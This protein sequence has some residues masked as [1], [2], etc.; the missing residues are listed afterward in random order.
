M[1]VS[2]QMLACTIIGL[3]L[4]VRSARSASLQNELLGFAQTLY[5]EQD[6]YRAI[7]EFK[8]FLFLYPKDARAPAATF[9]IG[10]SYLKGEKWLA[11]QPYFE[12]LIHSYSS[13]KIGQEAKFS[14]GQ[15]YFLS[16]QYE[17]ALEEWAHHPFQY[18]ALYQRAWVFFLQ[19]KQDAALE[20]LDALKTSSY[21]PI[22]QAFSNEIKKWKELP[23][24]SPW[25][26]GGLSAILPGAGQWYT[27]HYWDGI[28]ALAVN[29]AFAY[30][31]Y[32]TIRHQYYVAFGILTLVGSGFYGG[33]IFSAIASAHKF[34]RNVQETHQANLIQKYGLTVDWT[35]SSL[36]IHWPMM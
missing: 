36:A 27:G 25:L 2:I 31:I 8:R 15:L 14:L 28:S 29:S 1:K 5:Q 17:Y 23:F 21:Q 10:Y 7:S 6:Y 24:K 4:Q 35:G 26:A 30:G 18:P 11:A 13:Q 9:S 12:K 22:G 19:H 32:A 20:A 34:N 33:N 16:K 3:M